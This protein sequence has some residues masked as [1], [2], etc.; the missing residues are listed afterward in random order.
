MFYRIFPIIFNRC[1]IVGTLI[2][3]HSGA[4]TTILKPVV[5]VTIK[6]T[7][8]RR[9]ESSSGFWAYILSPTFVIIICIGLCSSFDSYQFDQFH[10]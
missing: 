5:S 9:V 6:N 8:N 2:N 1:I 10:F 7:A 3:H 4:T